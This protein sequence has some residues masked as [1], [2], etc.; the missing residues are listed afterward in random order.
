V[1]IMEFIGENGVSAPLLRE[2]DIKNPQQTYQRLLVNLKKLYRKARLVHADLSEYNVMIWKNKPILF[3]VSQAV[4]R[5]HPMAE[6]F[7]RRDIN[8][9]N[10]YFKRL[11]VKVYSTEET[12]RRVTGVKA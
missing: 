7:L 11:G 10:Y 5:E 12:Y 2:A 4:L 1:L 8:N 6:Q 3:D 9:I